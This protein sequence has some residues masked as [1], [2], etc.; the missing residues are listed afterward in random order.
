M[1]RKTKVTE[2]L[3][4]ELGGGRKKGRHFEGKGR[5]CSKVVA[6]KKEL[7]NLTT[8]MELRYTSTRLERKPEPEY[9]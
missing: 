5:G 2:I 1:S 9:I 3:G 6:Q 7:K 8:P 4:R